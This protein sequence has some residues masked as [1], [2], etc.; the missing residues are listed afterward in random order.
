MCLSL[1]LG[2][3]VWK[4]VTTR[5]RLKRWWTFSGPGPCHCCTVVSLRRPPSSRAM[6]TA[7]YEP[8]SCRVRG[9]CSVWGVQARRVHS[10]KWSR[11]QAIMTEALSVV[12]MST[13]S[14]VRSHRSSTLRIISAV[15]AALWSSSHRLQPSTT[16]LNASVSL[17]MKRR[18][19]PIRP[20]WFLVV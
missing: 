6:G 16:L 19:M 15:P 18:I 5:T 7:L 4:L 12:A 17:S 13:S 14:S 3:L 2:R 10:G 11:I 1:L 9:S 20:V 8:S